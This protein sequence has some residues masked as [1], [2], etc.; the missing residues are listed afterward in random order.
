[1]SEQWDEIRRSHYSDTESARQ[2]RIR[3]WARQL[4]L[5][6]LRRNGLWFFFG[7]RSRSLVSPAKGLTDEDA[8][9]L[10]QSFMEGVQK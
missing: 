4:E 7:N 9:E 1:M 3:S 10:L 2:Q 5:A 6:P 8:Q